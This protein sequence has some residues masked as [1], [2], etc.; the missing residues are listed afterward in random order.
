M[1]KFT[2][3][4]TYLLFVTVFVT[5]IVTIPFGYTDYHRAK[6]HVQ[7]T[8]DSLFETSVKELVL[9][10]MKDNYFCGFLKN[11]P[12]KRKIH[13]YET[14][15]YKDK[16]TTFTYFSRIVDYETNLYRGFLDAS[17]NIDTL[18]AT[19]MK[20]AFDRKCRENGIYDTKSAIR[21][22]AD[23]IKYYNDSTG[24]INPADYDYKCILAKQGVFE[25]IT[26]T[27]FF[28][29]SPLTY[30]RLMPKA[31]I[32][33]GGSIILL[34]VLL[35]LL[36]KMKLR[37]EK[38]RGLKILK[39]G[40]IRIFHT[41]IKTQ[42]RTYMNPYN[43]T[44][45]NISSQMMHTL[46]FF[47][48]REKHEATVEQLVRELWPKRTPNEAISNRTTTIERANELLTE[49]TCKHIILYDKKKGTYQL[50]EICSP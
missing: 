50:Q 48:T 17:I 38:H 29:C 30:W 49:M 47:I 32:Y 18:Q 25:E 19:D 24:V 21:I 34:S 15:I 14:R 33:I 8:K 3:N 1:N 27:A 26:L 7:Q 45:G 5:I 23:S 11:D 42:E 9:G 16:D 28:K 4:R 20:K 46:L 40:D 12:Q 44:T 13:A 31:G 2:R 6:N 36:W 22:Y 41:I 39:N 37:K 10:K 35:F 43:F